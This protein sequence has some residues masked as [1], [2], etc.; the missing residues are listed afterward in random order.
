MD[1]FRVL[2]YERV[3]LISEKWSPRVLTKHHNS[4]ETGFFD[5]NYISIKTFASRYK[6]IH[7]LVSQKHL[8]VQLQFFTWTT[9]IWRVKFKFFFQYHLIKKFQ[10]KLTPASL[11]FI[12]T[13]FS[14]FDNATLKSQSIQILSPQIVWSGHYPRFCY[15][16]KEI[17]RKQ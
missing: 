10:T 5:Q 15:S 9:M 8:H 14:G 17:Q 12:K 16:S 13:N 6:H 7:N 1:W 4:P 2:R 11:Q 3:K